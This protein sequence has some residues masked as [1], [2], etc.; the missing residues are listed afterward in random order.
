[1]K[2]RHCHKV[3]IDYEKITIENVSGL[4]RVFHTNCFFR[5]IGDDVQIARQMLE[6]IDD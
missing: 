3:I 4:K 2:C 1:M 6:A 5:A